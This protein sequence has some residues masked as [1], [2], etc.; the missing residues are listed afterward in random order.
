MLHVSVTRTFEQK[1]NK[2]V[3]IQ[4]IEEPLAPVCYHGHNAGLVNEHYRVQKPYFAE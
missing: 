1:H 2:G 4:F 3:S